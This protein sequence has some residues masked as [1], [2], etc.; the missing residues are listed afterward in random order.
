MQ[1]ADAT[2][3]RLGELRALGARLAVDDFGT[4]V[5]VIELPHT[6]VPSP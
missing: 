1:D 4:E 3:R 5:L 6:G 2:A